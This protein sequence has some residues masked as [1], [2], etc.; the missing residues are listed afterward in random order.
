M[1]K[2]RIRSL[3]FSYDL[4]T[5]V[6]SSLVDVKKVVIAN[7]YN[8]HALV[9]CRKCIYLRARVVVNRRNSH[10]GPSCTLRVINAVRGKR[11]LQWRFFAMIRVIGLHY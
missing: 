2:R 3:L 9:K 4:L 10:I 8:A 11:Q 6:T 7:F 1:E 5:T